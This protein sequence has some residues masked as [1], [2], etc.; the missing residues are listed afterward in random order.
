MRHQIVAFAVASAL[1]SPCALAGEP[2]GVFQKDVVALHDGREVNGREEFA[3]DH[4]GYRY[5]FESRESLEEFRW[6]R[7]EYEVQLG[8]GCGRMGPLSGL[9]DPDRWVIH[10][11]RLYIFASDGCRDGFLKDPS[12]VLET[13][14]EAPTATPE[15]RAR[16]LA[17][18]RRA[19][20]WAGGAEAIGGLGTVKIGRAGPEESGGRTYQV[21]R[22]TTLGP[23]GEIRTDESWDAK[24]WAML[25]GFGNGGAMSPDS[26]RELHP[27]QVRAL[28]RVRN[29]EL[30][31]V[32]RAAAAEDCLVVSEHDE[33]TPIQRVAIY[34]DHTLCTL[35]VDEETGEIRAIEFR[36]RGPS[37]RLGTVRREF[38]SWREMGGVRIPTG[39][40]AWFDGERAESLDRSM[41]EVEAVDAEGEA[42]FAPAG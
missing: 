2:L 38:T 12:S 7:S 6:N 39:W 40:T 31:T 21:E 20:E 25:A 11:G 42:I 32:L 4:G 35:E 18:M 33:T 36:G 24:R 17:L 28:E 19:V 10:D 3:F 37:A 13:D 27:Q 15:S 41:M 1:A 23:R 5:L 16:G 22:W 8:G 26:S 14:D 34:F 9:G 30:V 29:H